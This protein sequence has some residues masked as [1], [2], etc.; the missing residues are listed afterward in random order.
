M[1]RVSVSTTPS[2]SRRRST[3]HGDPP[4]GLALGGARRSDDEHVLVRHR[5]ERDQLQE[6]LAFDET[7]PSVAKGVAHLGGGG[8]W[9]RRHLRGDYTWEGRG[10]TWAKAYQR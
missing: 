8:E 1:P 6:G 7:T 4:D 5:G 9:W 10:T 3:S 2:R